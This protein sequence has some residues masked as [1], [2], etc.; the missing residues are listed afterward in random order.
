MKRLIIVWVLISPFLMG[1]LCSVNVQPHQISRAERRATAFAAGE[2][3]DQIISQILYVTPFATP[4]PTISPTQEINVSAIDGGIVNPNTDA[5]SPRGDG[6]TSNDGSNNGSPGVG[7][8]PPANPPPPPPVAPPTA[9]PTQAVTPDAPPVQPTPQST[10]APPPPPSQPADPP[11]P[12]NDDDNNDNDN[13][14]GNN[15][16]IP[17][18]TDS[19]ATSAPGTATSVPATA[20]PEPTTPPTTEPS[21]T[22]EP[23]IPGL[24]FSQEIYQADEA[25]GQ[26]LIT[27]L[28][29]QA[30]SQ[31]VEVD[32]TT[33]D[34]S[35]VANF[36]YTSVNGRL[37][38]TVGQTATTFAVP[39]TDNET[40]DPDVETVQ[41][42]L[43]NPL[44]SV[45]NREQAMLEINDNDALPTLQ[46]SAAQFS[47]QENQTSLLTVT[48]SH[49]SGKY[50]SV[51]YDLIRAS[52][53]T[54]A[55]AGVDYHPF[56]FGSL[57]F[58]PDATGNTPTVV[59][60]IW[61][62]LIADPATEPAKTVGFELL[63]LSNATLGPISTTVLT[64]R[65]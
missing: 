63:N 25:D 8:P 10:S 50:I 56:N 31:S 5:S 17:E 37:V 52:S 16:S 44:N 58:A 59:T 4:T 9:A 13:G 40:D 11:A 7:D 2:Y 47:V 30:T 49:P 23:V 14:D 48:L 60:M 29:D 19:P 65:D 45:I 20:T 61:S 57:G 15:P 62:E 55:V 18:P 38:F 36:D 12:D 6:S 32:Y 53:V 33:A 24:S 26:R 35:A 34:G 54:N 27:V 39:I 51:N 28:L 41:L 64:I 42:F 21:A 46:F 22:P 3:P 1:A 43:S